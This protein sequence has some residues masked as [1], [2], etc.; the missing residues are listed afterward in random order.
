MKSIRWCVDYTNIN[1][2]I[3]YDW[4]IIKDEYVLTI[5]IV[6]WSIE[7]VFNREIKPNV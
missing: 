1:I 2:G 6:F 3:Q 4:G 7:I 5:N